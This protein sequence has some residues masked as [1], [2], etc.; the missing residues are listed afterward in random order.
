MRELELIDA[1]EKVFACD[2]PAVVRWLGD[3]AAVVRARGYAVTSVDTA[4]DGV[5][6]RSGLQSPREIG[7]RA[8]AVEKILSASCP[9]IGH[10][11]PHPECVHHLG[12]LIHGLRRQSARR[13]K[14]YQGLRRRA[15][16][17]F[18]CKGDQAQRDSATRNRKPHQG[19]E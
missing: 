8:L 3:D 6:F 12:M 9:E 10:P 19:M 5:H 14:R 16:E 17:H 4:V 7:H 11:A 18:G 2:N 13:G 1:L 15:C